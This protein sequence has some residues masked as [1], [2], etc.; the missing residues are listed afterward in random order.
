MG[1]GLFP[2]CQAELAQALG[3]RAE[4]QEAAE[5]IKPAHVGGGHL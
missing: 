1:A 3:G 5:A 2:T 4:L